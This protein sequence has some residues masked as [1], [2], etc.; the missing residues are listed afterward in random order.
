MGQREFDST[1]NVEAWVAPL[2]VVNKYSPHT[3]YNSLTFKNF[4]RLGDIITSIL[5]TVYNRNRDDVGEDDL[6]FTYRRIIHLKS[7]LT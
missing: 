7:I 2:T 3:S 4:C 5:Q 1:D 6:N